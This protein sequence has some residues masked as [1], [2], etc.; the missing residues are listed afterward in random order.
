VP[1][2]AR[3]VCVKG[4]DNNVSSSISDNNNTSACLGI[5]R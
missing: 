4:P 3:C 1:G 5:M 2:G